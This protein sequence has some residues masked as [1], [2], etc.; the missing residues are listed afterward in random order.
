MLSLFLLLVIAVMICKWP[1]TVVIKDKLPKGTNKKDYWMQLQ[2][3]GAEYL[4]ITEDEVRLK[5]V[6]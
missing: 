4:E 6:K 5:I 1:K 3:E 2:N